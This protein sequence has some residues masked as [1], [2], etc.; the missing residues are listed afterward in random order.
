MN[1][2]KL[3]GRPEELQLSHIIPKYVYRWMKKTGPGRFRLI[4]KINKPIH[5]GFKEYLLCKD[6]E[7]LLAQKEKWFKDNLFDKYLN[8]SETYFNNDPDL[9]YFAISIAWRVLIY[10]K[11]SGDNYRHK[12]KY[13]QAEKE[14]R[15]F[16]LNNQPLNNF[17]DIHLVFVP[18]NLK[19]DNEVKNA[20]SYFYRAVDI[21]IAENDD[22]AFVYAKFSRF[23]LIGEIL[24]INESEYIGT[25]ISQLST[26]GCEQEINDGYF[27]DYLYS[28][29]INMKSYYDLSL[30]QQKQN[31]LF[32]IDKMDQLRNSDYWNILKRDIK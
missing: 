3:C 19:L 4:G 32:Y 24:G 10:F 7:G 29:V 22:K 18:E 11:D 9:L 21:E 30:K 14:W 5:D 17:K 1:N 8:A 6:C 12:V 13:D 26:I 31:D 2:C 23:I 25:N 16:L 20:Y 15:L 27:I 28:R